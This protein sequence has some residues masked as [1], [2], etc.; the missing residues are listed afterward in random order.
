MLSYPG[1]ETYVTSIPTSVWHQTLSAPDALD[2]FG[3]AGVEKVRPINK[4]S[5]PPD[6]ALTIL[7][8]SDLNKYCH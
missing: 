4:E 1:F 2:F 5:L 3:A 7:R 8:S 6:L